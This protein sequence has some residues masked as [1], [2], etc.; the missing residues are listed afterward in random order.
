MIC[1]KC[2]ME[3]KKG[4][5]KCTDCGTDLVERLEDAVE[6]MTDLINVPSDYATRLNDFLEY[7]GMTTELTQAEEEIGRAHV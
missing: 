5:L 1:P 7:S 6:E 2:G 3:F 4:V